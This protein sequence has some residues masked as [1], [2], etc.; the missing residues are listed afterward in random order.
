MK[1]DDFRVPP[2][3][4]FKH[5]SFRL[6]GVLFVPCDCHIKQ[7]LRHSRCCWRILCC[8]LLHPV[9][10]W[11]VPSSSELDSP[12]RVIVFS[13][14]FTSLEFMLETEFVLREVWTEFLCTVYIDCSPQK[15]KRDELVD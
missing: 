8:A 2:A 3:V 9:D 11:E 5:F 6:H 1:P 14:I 12:I 4:T 15:D 10:V 13:K 7:G